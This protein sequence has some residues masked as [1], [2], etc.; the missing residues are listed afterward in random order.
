[1]RAF[2]SA[3]VTYLLKKLPLENKLLQSL[4]CLN[5]QKLETASP[6]E[7]EYVAKKLN[8]PE[9][10]VARVSDEWKVLSIAGDA[11]KE[12]PKRVDHFWR[13]VFEIEQSNGKP[14]YPF[15]AKVVKHALVLPHGNADVE[16]A[17]SENTSVV[18]ADRASM[19]E[20]AIIGLRTVKDTVKFSDP[21]LCRPEK[22]PLG[23]KVLA[24]AR[25]AHAMYLQRLE[26]EKQQEQQLKN[27]R[28][29]K[30]AEE[31]KRKNERDELVSQKSSLLEKETSLAAKEKKLNESL[32]S[33]H[34]LLKEGN[35]KMKTAIEKADFQSAQTAQMMIETATK[36]TAEYSEEMKDLRTEQKAVEEKKRK[37][38]DKSIAAPSAK[39]PKTS[40]EVPST[41]KGTHGTRETTS[42][43][44]H[45]STGGS[46]HKSSGAS[47]SKKTD[48]APKSSG[49]GK[50]I[51]KKSRRH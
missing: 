5:P 37:L 16:R 20:A 34:D 22:L 42:K 2:F 47:P 4:G 33:A 39:I 12:K 27:E 24:A 29:E 36:K 7:I 48:A 1:M 45:S 19:G 26:T 31:L 43:S 10:E 6:Q 21:V 14:K 41:S 3:T 15:L 23:K 32:S 8:I 25:S 28:E 13:K 44:K 18:T 9:E 46:S 40:S 35:E 11:P 49:K 17:L 38:L 51:H 50:S 30:R